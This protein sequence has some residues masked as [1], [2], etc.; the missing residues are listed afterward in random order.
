MV[1]YDSKNINPIGAVQVQILYKEQNGVLD[2]YSIKAGGPPI[3][4]RDFFKLF[5]LSIYNLKSRPS[6]NIKVPKN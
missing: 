5:N 1:T 4:D 6:N 2:L 3:L